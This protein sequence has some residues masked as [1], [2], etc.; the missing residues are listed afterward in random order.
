MTRR[1]FYFFSALTF[2][3]TACKKDETTPTNIDTKASMKQSTFTA[4]NTT[5]YGYWL[6]TPANPT[7]NMPL[8]VYLHGGSGRGTDL[9]LVISGS[10]PKFLYDST[11]KDISAYVLMPQCPA[12]LT[13][14][15][16]AT[17]LIEMIDNVKT[18]KQINANKIS[19]TGHSLGGTGTWKIGA[20]YSTKFSC[21]APLSGSV[22][23]STASSYTSIPVWAFVGSADVVVDPISTTTIVPM[24]NSLGGN[25]QVKTYGGA[26]HF[27][28]PDL[29]YKDATVN[30]LTWMLNKTK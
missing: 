29:A 27:D 12:S 7:A 16:I 2:L 1:L 6:Y 13:W 14:E 3:L 21:I 17:S 5:T 26:T 15:Q 24:I 20:T 10:L 4:S 23:T 18:A 22:Q 11:V 19:L 28:V 8:I 25:A 30:L 9:N